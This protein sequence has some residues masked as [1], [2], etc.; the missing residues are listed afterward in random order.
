MD[1]NK[2]EYLLLFFIDVNVFRGHFKW[3]VGG[4]GGLQPYVDFE[5]RLLFGWLDRG[6]G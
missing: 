6:A 1:R 2:L 4:G 3:N 5:P